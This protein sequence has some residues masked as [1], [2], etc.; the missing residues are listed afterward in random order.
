MF[1]ASAN[2]R[3][4]VDCVFRAEQ[5]GVN[6]SSNSEKENARNNGRKT[7]RSAWNSA[8][9]NVTPEFILGGRRSD[10]LVTREGNLFR[11]YVPKGNSQPGRGPGLL[12]FFAAYFVKDFTAAA[13][14]SFTSKTV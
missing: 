2:E 3:Q 4:G 11:D 1:P 10:R 7:A 9:K 8:P 13:S 12:Q 5:I 6:A 14:S